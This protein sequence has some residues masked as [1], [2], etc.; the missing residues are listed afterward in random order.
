MNEK[1]KIKAKN[2]NNSSTQQKH[3]LGMVSNKC[4]GFHKHITFVWYKN[5]LPDLNNLINLFLV[6]MSNIL[7]LRLLHVLTASNTGDLAS[8]LSHAMAIGVTCSRKV[9]CRRLTYVH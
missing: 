9:I 1:K 4:L 3:R 8:R 6:K 5:L 7:I 2:D